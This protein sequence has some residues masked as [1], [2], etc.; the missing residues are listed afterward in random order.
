[1]NI[2]G[3]YKITESKIKVKN[4]PLTYIKQ[5]KDIVSAGVQ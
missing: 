3:T 2:P 1:M 5:L 4:K